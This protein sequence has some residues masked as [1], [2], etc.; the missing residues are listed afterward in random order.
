VANG[1][2]ADV[3]TCKVTKMFEVKF[4][5]LCITEPTDSYS[6]STDFVLQKMSIKIITPR[7]L[8]TACP[9]QWNYCEI[10]VFL[11]YF[12]CEWMHAIIHNGHVI[13]KLCDQW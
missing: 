4:M 2:L 11:C 8:Q 13:L 9:Y 5:H 12:C 1:Q 3:G 10:H 7:C 6:L